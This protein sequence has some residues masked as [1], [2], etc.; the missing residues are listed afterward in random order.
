MTNSAFM[1]ICAAG[2]A[3]E[4]LVP[5][6]L[7]LYTDYRGDWDG[8]HTIIQDVQSA[9]GSWIHAYLHRK[10]GDRSNAQYWYSRVNRKMPAYSLEQEWEEIVS[11]LLYSLNQ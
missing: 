5:T 7:A 3:D 11:V 2:T 6:L 10:E 9:E 4:S 8:A 1:T